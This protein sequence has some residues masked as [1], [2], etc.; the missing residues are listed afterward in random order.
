MKGVVDILPEYGELI[1]N[2]QSPWM[3]ADTLC[4]EAPSLVNAMNT[5]KTRSYN[6]LWLNGGSLVTILMTMSLGNI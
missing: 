3:M 2:S 5:A 1:T 4:A 6:V